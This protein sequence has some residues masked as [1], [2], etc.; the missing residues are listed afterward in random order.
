MEESALKALDRKALQK[1]AKVNRICCSYNLY[2]LTSATLD[3][4]DQ[5]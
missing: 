3:E 5:S 1:L 2:L 4:R